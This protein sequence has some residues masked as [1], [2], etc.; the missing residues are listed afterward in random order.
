MDDT[1]RDGQREL[2]AHVASMKSG[3]GESRTPMRLL[4]RQCPEPVRQPRNGLRYVVVVASSRRPRAPPPGF[5]PGSLGVT[6]QYTAVVLGRNGGAMWW[7]LRAGDT[8]PRVVA[9]SGLVRLSKSRAAGCGWWVGR[10]GF[11]P[12][13][14]GSEPVVL[15]LDDP[16][17]GRVHVHALFDHSR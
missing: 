14:T 15:P 13:S 10:P 4:A 1:R 2:G 12:G 8:E 7:S 6:S 3:A 9:G 11:E 17:R 16:P 5:E